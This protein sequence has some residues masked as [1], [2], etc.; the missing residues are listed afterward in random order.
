MIGVDTNVLVRFLVQ[1]DPDQSARASKVFERLS[2]A[3]P[4]YLA[5]VVLV[6]AYWVLTRAYGRAKADVI[7]V[8]TDLISSEGVVVDASLRIARALESASAGVDFPDALIAQACRA[9]R[10]S[11]VV[12]FDQR[13]IAELGFVSP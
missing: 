7:S 1:D 10:C 3:N 9:K 13:A 4:G 6:E 5:D 2:I 8:L 12:S 11:S